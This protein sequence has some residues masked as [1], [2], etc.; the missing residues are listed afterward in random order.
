MP[1][2]SEKMKL[3]REYDRR[4]KLTDEQREKLEDDIYIEAH[5]DRDYN[6]LDIDYNNLTIMYC[7]ER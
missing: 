6:I 4:V 7:F 2:K 3:P 1:Y 5:I